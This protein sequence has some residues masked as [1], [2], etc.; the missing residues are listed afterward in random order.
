MNP[1]E[2][3][4]L[5]MRFVSHPYVWAPLIGRFFNTS[6]LDSRRDA[7]PRVEITFAYLAVGTVVGWL[8]RFIPYLVIALALIA[9]LAGT[10][11]ELRLY[12]RR[13]AFIN[14]TNN[15]VP[16][17]VFAWGIYQAMCFY[18]LGAFLGFSL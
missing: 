10:V 7:W 2:E 4:A 8:Q 18:F 9:L 11:P 3:R 14:G 5:H 1:E 13:N 16:L 17:P 6:W 12:R 15:D